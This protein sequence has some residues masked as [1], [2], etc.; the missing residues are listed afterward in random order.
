MQSGSPNN[1][2]FTVHRARDGRATH[3]QLGAAATEQ[4]GPETPGQKGL[5]RCRRRGQFVGISLD[6]FGGHGE[7]ML[8]WCNFGG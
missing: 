2:G 6:E 8:S 1:V 7:P 3:R 5:R 4:P